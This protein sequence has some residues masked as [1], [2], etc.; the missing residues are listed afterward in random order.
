MLHALLTYDF[1]LQ[2][3]QDVGSRSTPT[4]YNIAALWSALEGSIP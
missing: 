3:V 2:Y 1:D 4:L